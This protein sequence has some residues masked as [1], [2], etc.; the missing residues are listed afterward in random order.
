MNL[1][2]EIDK[3]IHF[4]I[5]EFPI[6][7]DYMNNELIKHII[8]SIIND[9]IKELSMEFIYLNRDYIREEND[10]NYHNEDWFQEQISEING[11]IMT[12]IFKGHIKLQIWEI[13]YDNIHQ[14]LYNFYDDIQPIIKANDIDNRIKILSKLILPVLAKLSAE[15]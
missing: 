14:V 15:Y 4:I 13:V 11:K 5:D 9:G 6:K 2:R 1:D 7:R 8:R 12:M 3:A 10:N